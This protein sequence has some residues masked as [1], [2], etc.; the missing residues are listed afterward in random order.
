[1][2]VTAVSFTLSVLLSSGI[3]PRYR[4]LPGESGCAGTI[5]WY[6][7]CYI[8]CSKSNKTMLLRLNQSLVDLLCF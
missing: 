4:L 1:M 5:F 8:W 7:T 3:V 6:V 2:L